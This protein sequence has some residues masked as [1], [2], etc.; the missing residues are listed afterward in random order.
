MILSN[1]LV[2]EA[3][4]HSL[5]RIQELWENTF[6]E[7]A[8]NLG[9]ILSQFTDYFGRYIPISVPNHI[10]EIEKNIYGKFIKYKWCRRSKKDIL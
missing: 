2:C 4:S 6:K 5:Q 1:D 8:E 3:N 10:S 9:D 7:Y